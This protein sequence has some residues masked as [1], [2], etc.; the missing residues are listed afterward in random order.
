MKTRCVNPEFPRYPDYGGRGIKV[1]DRWLEFENFLADMGP[2][3]G[4]GYSID[5]IDNDGHY[6][7]GNCRWATTV[8]QSRNRRDNVMITRGDRA[9]CLIDWCDELGLDY[10]ITQNRL[11]AG[12]TVDRAFETPH[13]R[14]A[15]NGRTTDD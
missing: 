7:P 15:N 10:K 13:T 2:K 12:W 8:E 11:M 4:P 9:Q 6:E 1:C 5:R 3:P 14:R